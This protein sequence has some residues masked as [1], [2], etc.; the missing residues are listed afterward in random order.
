MIS[1]NTMTRQTESATRVSL[2]DSERVQILLRQ[3]MIG[4]LRAFFSFLNS[5]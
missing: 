4:K 1:E 3:Y 2:F 5:D